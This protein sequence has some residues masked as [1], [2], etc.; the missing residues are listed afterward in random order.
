LLGH[1]LSRALAVRAVRHVV[2][3]APRTHLDAARTVADAT[4]RP[5]VVDVVPGG[6]ER[7]ASVAA[8]LAAL[9]PD[10]RV[11]LVHDAARALAPPELFDAV[12]AA[13]GAGNEAVVPGLPVV[14]TVKAVDGSDMVE[15][16][17]DRGRLR[18]VQTPQG[19]TRDLLEQAHASGASASDDAGLAERIGAKVR[20]VPGD[21]RAMKV[22]TPH[23]LAVAE[24]YLREER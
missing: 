9:D 11:V 1:A 10:D 12:I 24:V 3:V 17:P 4:A 19:F 16:T 2:V 22:T 5:A 15:A 7:T 21:P 18:A 20:V 6:A 23:D 8:G 13:V 14:D